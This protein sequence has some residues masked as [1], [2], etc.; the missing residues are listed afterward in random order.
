MCTKLKIKCRR[1]S[2]VISFLCSVARPLN[3]ACSLQ[4]HVLHNC[5]V[6]AACMHAYYRYLLSYYTQV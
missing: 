4:A 1:Y 6:T 2:L 3:N 5:R